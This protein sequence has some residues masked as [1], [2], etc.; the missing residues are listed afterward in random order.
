MFEINLLVYQFPYA[1]SLSISYL[2]ILTTKV[3]NIFILSMNDG[4]MTNVWEI[5]NVK[6]CQGDSLDVASDSMAP[7]EEHNYI[8]GMY[9][10]LM[11]CEHST[12]TND[13]SWRG[14]SRYD[15]NTVRI[16]RH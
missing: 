3:M 11:H 2:H 6:P 7:Q 1:V 15:E 16:H 12:V 14:T 5:S 4:V 10:T 13:D 9:T 8:V